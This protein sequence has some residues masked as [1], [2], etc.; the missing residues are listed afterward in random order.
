M[1][2]LLTFAPGWNLDV[3]AGTML[4]RADVVM[5][6][7]PGAGGFAAI[8]EAKDL[9]ET[10]LIRGSTPDTTTD[11]MH[12]LLVAKLAH[13]IKGNR[14]V[15]LTRNRPTGQALATAFKAF[16]MVRM[17]GNSPAAVADATRH[18]AVMAERAERTQQ[19]HF[20][21]LQ[22]L[23]Y[24]PSEHYSENQDVGSVHSAIQN[25]LQVI[26]ADDL[27]KPEVAKAAQKVLDA[28]KAARD[29]RLREAL[30]GLTANDVPK[31]TKES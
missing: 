28:E 20:D 8:I 18:A 1:S 5:N 26:S 29:A 19:D 6:Q 10:I 31:K 13:E 3:P 4:I 22:S 12:K 16:K 30:R 9:P 27:R 11:G 7:R 14:A 25:L 2:A 17:L 21:R 15:I 23:R 24:E